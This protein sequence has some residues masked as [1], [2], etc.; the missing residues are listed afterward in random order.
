MNSVSHKPLIVSNCFVRIF[1]GEDTMN[2]NQFPSISKINL[3]TLFI[4]LAITLLSHTGTVG[5][6]TAFNFQ[7]RLNDGSSP[8]NGRYDL[9]FRLYDAVTGGNAV[10]N[11]LD[12]PNLVLI[13][14]VFSTTLDFGPSIFT[15][16][17]RFIEISVRP[18]TVASVSPNAY[19]ILGARQQIMSVPYAVRSLNAA[20]AEQAANATNASSAGFAN[21]AAT[22]QTAVNSQQLGGVAAS[23]YVAADTNGDVTFGGKV[24]VNGSVYQ[25]ANSSGLPKALLYLEPDGTI[26]NCFNGVTGQTA[27][28]CGFTVNHPELGRYKINVGFNVTNRIIVA[29]S[30][31]DLSGSSTCHDG[32]VPSVL[33]SS[34]VGVVN[35]DIRYIDEEDCGTIGNRTNAPFSMVIY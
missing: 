5:Q 8:A 15:G 16:G 6:T 14:G 23:R 27:N 24:T 25:P 2:L 18:T 31:S 11:P 29:S 21:S 3:L 1:V 17:D 20:N 12:R 30:G 35:I 10:G 13:N 28:T 22:A 9:Q 32:T 26:R 33:I 4:A 34:L 19:V 7:G